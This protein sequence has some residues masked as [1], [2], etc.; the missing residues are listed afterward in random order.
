M[1]PVYLWFGILLMVSISCSTL[2]VLDPLKPQ[3][4]S[5]FS[6]RCD[7]P[8]AV[9]EWQFIHAIEATMHNK[10]PSFL[11]GITVISSKKASVQCA[12]MSIEGLLL[13]EARSDQGRLVINRGISP[14]DSKSLAA[15]LMQEIKLI[16]LKPAG[17]LLET[18]RLKNGAY[19]CRYQG[20][21]HKI[22][23][24]VTK[25]DFS[26]EI[27]QYDKNN[28][29]IKSVKA[30]S[31]K[32]SLSSARLNLFPDRLQLTS[33]DPFGYSLDMKLI[34]AQSLE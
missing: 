5:E 7:L 8:F 25:T 14:F 30:Y 10:K 20:D 18:G 4:L 19:V 9:G 32:Q 29:L 11:I 21:E 26:W 6:D 16:F 2:P 13:F 31:N 33:Q 3:E 22:V 17:I 28:R 34:E 1:K 15:D 24:V 23:D 27:H 12:I